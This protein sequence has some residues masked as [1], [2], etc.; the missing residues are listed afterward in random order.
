MYDY[1][2]ARHRGTKVGNPGNLAFNADDAV[3]LRLTFGGQEHAFDAH[4]IT[5]AVILFAKKYAIPLARGW[6]KSLSVADGKLVL[7]LWM[8]MSC[9]T[10]STAAQR[11]S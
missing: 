3:A 5:A 11:Q 1:Y 9:A 4:E 7:K 8:G 10:V 2:R 6:C